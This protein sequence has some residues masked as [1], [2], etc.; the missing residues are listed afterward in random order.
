MPGVRPPG[1][2]P[3]PGISMESWLVRFDKNGVCASPKTRDALLDNVAGKKD[4]PIIFFSHGWNNDFAD[5]TDLYR[6]FL[7]EFEQVLEAHPVGGPSPIFVGL[8]WPSIWLPSDAGPAMAGTTEDAA[9]VAMNEAVLRE[10]L[11][12]LP[13]TTDRSR[14]YALLE[15]DKISVKEAHELAR[16]L[17]PA[18]NPGKQ[19][20]PEETQAD[21]A[22]I[23]GAISDLQRADNGKPSDDDIDAI[24]T[25]GGAGSADL[26]TASLLDFLDPRNAIRLAS[27][28]LMKDRAGTVGENGA[29][30][31]LRGLLQKSQAPLHV[32]GHSFGCKVVMS[33][34]AADPKP[35]RK[36]RS[37]LLLEPAISYLSFAETV[38]G[39]DG[40][41]GYRPVLDLV[42]TPVFSTYSASDFPLHAIYHLALLRR[43]DLG[44]AQIAAQVTSAGNPPNVYAALGGYG[45]R[46]SNESLI[47]PIP[48][49]GEDFNYPEK[50]R[51][52]GFDGSIG[53]RIDSH[54][55]VANPCTAW[56]L[57]RQ[58]SH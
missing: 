33:A 46:D 15:A 9:A 54:G 43:K 48:R 45:P 12:A 3:I 4:Q 29:A 24:G 8:T 38:P 58:M 50:A 42:E 31:L 13:P 52:V 25:V 57:R 41:G 20:G 53:N 35:G 30:A 39:R 26:A 22:N 2:Y 51:V 14:L 7:S 28:Y 6:R 19:E 5:A 32:I 34:L 49:P 11:D 27:L 23:V 36:V 17:A 10:I 44:E 40:P 1:P 55:G 37:V 56:V 16:L 47:E 21:E 18:L